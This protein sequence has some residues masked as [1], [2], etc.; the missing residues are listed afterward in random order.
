MVGSQPNPQTF[1]QDEKA[2]QDKRSSLLEPGGIPG[3]FFLCSKNLNTFK[4]G[5]CDIDFC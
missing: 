4:L 5:N 1:D 3:P 2:C